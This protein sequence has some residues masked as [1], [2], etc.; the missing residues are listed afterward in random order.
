MSHPT[1]LD[2]IKSF[3]SNHAYLLNCSTCGD[4]LRRVGLTSIV[5]TFEV[6]DCAEHDYKH[7]VEQLAHRDCF[8]AGVKA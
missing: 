2:L 1:G 4:D 3:R 6:C 8:K 7:L 5:Y